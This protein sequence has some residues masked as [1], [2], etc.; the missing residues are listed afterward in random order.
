MIKCDKF[1]FDTHVLIFRVHKFYKG[2][3]MTIGTLTHIVVVGGRTGSQSEIGIVVASGKAESHNGIRAA[4]SSRNP[5]CAATGSGLQRKS[6]GTST[7]MSVATTS[8]SAT[9]INTSLSWQSEK[10]KKGR[11]TRHFT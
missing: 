10:K 7:Q 2:R 5:R 9:P 11:T 6:G 4:I 3:N 1:N 8:Q